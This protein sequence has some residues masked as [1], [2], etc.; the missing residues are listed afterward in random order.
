M[1][2]LEM[3]MAQ[4]RTADNGKIGIGTHE[5]MGKL[6]YKIKQLAEGVMLN[7]HRHMPGIEHDAVLIVIDIGRILEAPLAAVDRHRYD[8]VI[9]SRRMVHP[10]RI[11]LVLLAE[12]ALRI[13][14][15]LCI[16]RSSNRLGVLFGL[17]KVDRD[18]EIA[19]FRRSN[20]LLIPADSVSADIV[21]VT[22]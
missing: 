9:L 15:L 18:V 2:A 3:V 10:S 17:G 20:P 12:K 8:A 14:G 1:T 6:P 22:A 21:G 19:V 11:A 16:L 13:A 4:D 5:I 7:L